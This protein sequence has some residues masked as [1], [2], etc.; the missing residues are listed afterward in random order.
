MATNLKHSAKSRY[1]PPLKGS[2][3]LDRKG[4]CKDLK[5][6]FMKCLKRNRNDNSKCRIESKNY[7]VCRMDKN[8]MEKEPLHQ[9]G[10]R[11][12]EDTGVKN[13]VKKSENDKK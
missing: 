10:Y 7:L 12:L 11:D 9:I 8:L 2:F 4:E 3:P 13:D 6:I 1:Q 5:E